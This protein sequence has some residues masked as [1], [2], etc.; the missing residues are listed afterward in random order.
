MN[1]KRVDKAKQ[2]RWSRLR[3]KEVWSEKP[4]DVPTWT[5]HRSAILSLAGGLTAFAGRFPARVCVSWRRG[6]LLTSARF[7]MEFEQRKGEKDLTL[8]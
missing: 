8:A 6:L 7:Q 4:L 1:E 2:G 5:P 3:Q